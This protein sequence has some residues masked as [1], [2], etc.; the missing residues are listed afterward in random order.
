M[1]SPRTF[2]RARWGIV[3]TTL[4]VALVLSACGGGGG[5]G[6]NQAATELQVMVINFSAKDVTATSSTGGDP[7]TVKQCVAQLVTFPL[8]DPF[9]F[10]IDNNAVID[11]AQLQGGVPGQGNSTVLAEVTVDKDGNAKVTREAYAGRTGGL[12]PPSKLYIESMCAGTPP[13]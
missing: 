12:A 8:A 3:F 11:S 9:T 5:G 10:S 13:K 1:T 7:Q 2:A 4:A 6:G